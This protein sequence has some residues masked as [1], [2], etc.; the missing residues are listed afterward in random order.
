MAARV[1]R[2][3]VVL[4]DYE[5][6]LPELGWDLP[7]SLVS[8]LVSLMLEPGNQVMNIVHC[9]LSCG[10]S[11]LSLMHGTLFIEFEVCLLEHHL[12]KDFADGGQHI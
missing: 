10:E 5:D 3:A 2:F 7:A 8:N 11:S 12:F 6:V 9:R 4:E 1:E